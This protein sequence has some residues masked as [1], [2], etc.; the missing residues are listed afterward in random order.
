[1]P[2]AQRAKQ[3]MPFAAL[4]GFQ[5]ALRKKE[6]ELG[7]TARPALSDEMAEEIDRALAGL[8]KGDAVSVTYYRS[9]EL[10]TAKGEYLKTDEVRRIITVGDIEI[11]VGDIFK[12]G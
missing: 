8:T 3:F 7:L 4:T 1:M 10:V 9:G 11:P 6:D 12:V 5:A 2:Q